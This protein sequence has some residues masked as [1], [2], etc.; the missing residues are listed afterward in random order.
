MV[1]CA[2]RVAMP[3]VRPVAARMSATRIATP[4]IGLTKPVLL[5]Q[6]V[7]SFPGFMVVD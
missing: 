5:G 1:L 7:V 4:K 3:S 6:P 2:Q